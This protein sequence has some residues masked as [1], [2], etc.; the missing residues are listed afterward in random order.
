MQTRLRTLDAHAGGAPLRLIVAGFP[1]VEG[2]S[3]RE[4]QDWIARHADHLRTALLAEP[5][6]HADMSGAVLTEPVTP[7]AA[8]GLVFMH[9]SGFSAMCGH[10]L[11]AAV[12]IAIE[13]GLLT[14]PAGLDAPL[15]IDTMAGPVQVRVD[16][17][18]G[19]DRGVCRVERVRYRSQPARVLAPGL[20]ADGKTGRLRADL[21]W[22]DGVYALVDAESAAV[23][24]TLEAL[25]ELR[26]SAG[27]L[28]EAL[29]PAAARH[30]PD[31]SIEGVV[32]TAPS[33]TGRADL[34]AVTVYDDLVVDRSPSGGGT[35]AALAVLAAMG[36][37]EEG[38]ALTVEGPSGLSFVARISGRDPEG[39]GAALVVEIEGA[40][41]VTGEHEFVLA[42]DD[43]LRFGAARE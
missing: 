2:R 42:D 21:V 40:A 30:V 1:S 13:R 12:T 34:R 22:A 32:F 41:F 43:P 37:V 19:V 16:L 10:G 35:T 36:L 15:V 17:A 29:Q 20:A 8:A 11:I 25:P 6:G 27:R 18:R 31:G 23:P 24:L 33:D 3:M 28:L 4:K 38:Q 7:G 26:R 5:R 39:D 9:A 14:G